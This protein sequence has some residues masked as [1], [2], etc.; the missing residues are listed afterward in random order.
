MLDGGLISGAY[1]QRNA[2]P[3]LTPGRGNEGPPPGSFIPRIDLACAPR[4][5]MHP[6]GGAW[7]G[8]ASVLSGL[9]T[10]TW[11]ELWRRF[12]RLLRPHGQIPA[13]VAIAAVR[14][15]QHGQRTEY[16]YDVQDQHRLLAYS[17]GRVRVSAE[18]PLPGKPWRA[19]SRLGGCN[20]RDL[21]VS[22][23]AAKMAWPIRGAFVVPREPH[24]RF[25]RH[26]QR[27]Q[28][29][30][31]PSPGTNFFPYSLCCLRSA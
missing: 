29:N 16:Q 2:G 31:T 7:P 3:A 28:G 24:S 6:Y 26:C 10:G 30:K 25:R 9:Q 22:S 15:S 5:R 1:C 13:N 11:R 19:Q 27:E 8:L 14:H 4:R 21:R 17:I 18:S 12:R 20:S 23:S